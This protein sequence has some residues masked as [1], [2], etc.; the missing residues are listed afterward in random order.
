MALNRFT[1]YYS[2]W[3]K[4][5]VGIAYGEQAVEGD[6]VLAL[7]EHREQRVLEVQHYR[8][9]RER[10]TNNF[11]RRNHGYISNVFRDEVSE[12]IPQKYLYLLVLIPLS[13]SILY[14]SNN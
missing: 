10:V 7:R 6:G 5:K 12:I 13:I 2:S 8:A 9:V 11:V 4:E 14:I 3:A 1:V